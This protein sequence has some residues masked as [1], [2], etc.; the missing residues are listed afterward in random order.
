MLSSLELTI[1]KCTGGPPNAVTPRCQFARKTFH[2]RSATVRARR[3]KS[4]R[5]VVEVLIFVSRLLSSSEMALGDASRASNPLSALQRDC[6]GVLEPKRRDELHE[7][8]IWGAWWQRH[9][10]PI[11]QDSAMMQSTVTSQSH[12]LPD[13]KTLTSK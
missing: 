6:E 7:D 13:A 3:D 5:F 1:L 2:A 11:V 12:Q 4:S 10:G 9:R 8:E